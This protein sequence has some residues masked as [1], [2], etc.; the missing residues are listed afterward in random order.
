MMYQMLYLSSINKR[1]AAP[2]L[3]LV[4]LDVA[5]FTLVNPRRAPSVLVV[6][7][8]FL[9]VITF[10]VLLSRLLEFAAKFLS[11]SRGRRK[12]LTLLMTICVAVSIGMQSIGQFSPRDLLAIVPIVAILYFYL[13]YYGSQNE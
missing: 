10:Y 1:K 3:A 4:A 13:S 9:L 12:K 2:L 5:V 11:L 7:G 8:F 6:A